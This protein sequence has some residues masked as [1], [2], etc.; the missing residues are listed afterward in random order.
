MKNL[1]WL[2]VKNLLV[3]SLIQQIQWHSKQ[4]LEASN[5]I[6]LFFIVVLYKVYKHRDNNFNSCQEDVLSC[7][8]M[9][10][11]LQF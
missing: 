1:Y 10:C 3:V 5:V 4:W 11:K 2:V 8:F 9:F 7:R 6:Y